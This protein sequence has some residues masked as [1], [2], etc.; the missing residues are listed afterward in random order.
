MTYRVGDVVVQGDKP[1]NIIHLVFGR[2]TNDGGTARTLRRRVA[3][4]CSAE[5]LDLMML[6]ACRSRDGLTTEHA[7]PEDTRPSELA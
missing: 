1:S 2:R 3:L 6:D 4:S 7:D 5:S